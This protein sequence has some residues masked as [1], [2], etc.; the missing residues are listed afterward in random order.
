MGIVKLRKGPVAQKGSLKNLYYELH[1][2]LRMTSFRESKKRS[3][4]GRRKSREVCFERANKWTHTY[5]LEQLT[6]IEILNI[7]EGE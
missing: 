3:E 5:R 4:V 6:A 7:R 1:L 2:V